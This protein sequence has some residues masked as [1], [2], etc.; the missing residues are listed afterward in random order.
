MMRRADLSSGTGS[1]RERIYH[2]RSESDRVDYRA[3][4]PNEV[5]RSVADRVVMA[6]FFGSVC[7]TF[8]EEWFSGSLHAKSDLHFMLFVGVIGRP[9][10]RLFTSAKRCRGASKKR[11]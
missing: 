10:G 9:P 5:P 8:S 3:H 11:H 7:V 2:T 6:R 1:S 4:P